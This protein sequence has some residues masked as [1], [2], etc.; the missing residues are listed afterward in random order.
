LFHQLS[1]N[2]DSNSEIEIYKKEQ[3]QGN[4]KSYRKSVIRYKNNSENEMYFPHFSFKLL[5]ETINPE[6]ILFL[7]YSLLLERKIILV[8]SDY[9]NNAIIIESILSLLY[10]LYFSIILFIT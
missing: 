8:A 10:P 3:H 7:V 4:N 2:S 1:W 9:S 5:C 6:S